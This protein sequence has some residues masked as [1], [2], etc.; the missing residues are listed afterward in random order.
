MPT[1]PLSGP[2]STTELARQKLILK[3]AIAVLVIGAGLIVF[4]ARSVALP[5]RLFVASTDL[6]LAAVLWLVLR[7]KFSGK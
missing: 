1:N 3:V 7:Q 5:L 6:V 2:S 4:L